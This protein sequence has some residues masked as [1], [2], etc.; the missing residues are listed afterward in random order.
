M[1]KKFK[2][3]NKSRK[4]LQQKLQQ[5]PPEQ[6][7]EQGKALLE[8]GKAR[9]A[10]EVLKQADKKLGP[11]DMIRQ[12]LFQAYL[13]REEQLR[14]KGMIPEA[15][16]VKNLAL[17]VMPPIDQLS[18]ADVLNMVSCASVQEA[19]KLYIDF[20]KSHP[21]SVRFDQHVAYRLM[22]TDDWQPLEMLESSHPIRRDSLPVREAVSRM[23]Q[24]EWEEALQVLKVVPRISPYAP[25]KLFCRAMVLFYQENDNEMIQT[26]SR[27]PDDFPLSACIESMK[28]SVGGNIDSEKSSRPYYDCSLWGGAANLDKLVTG[29]LTSLKNRQIKQLK[30]YISDLAKTIFP[31]S[32]VVAIQQILEILLYSPQ[33]NDI[34]PSDFIDMCESLLPKKRSVLVLLKSNQDNPRDYVGELMDYLDCLSSEISDLENRNMVWG[35]ILLYAARKLNAKKYSQKGI[36]RVNDANSKLLGIPEGCNDVNEAVLC[37]VVRSIELDPLNR[38]AYEFLIDLP[39]HSREAKDKVEDSLQKMSTE[40]PDDPFPCLELATLYYEKNAFRKAEHVLDEA[41]RR[42]PHDNRVIDRS[43]LSLVISA[44][45]N[46]NRKKHHLVL[47][48]LEKAEAFNSKRISPII[49]EKKILFDLI[50]HPDQFSK[51]TVDFCP[52]L[53]ILDRIRVMALLIL[54]MKSHGKPF[55]SILTESL[56]KWLTREINRLTLTTTDII[57]L[58]SPFPK[59]CQVVLPDKHIA[60]FLLGINKDLFGIIPDA[61]LI[62]IFELLFHQDILSFM[63]EELQKRLRKKNQTQVLSMQFFLITI[64]RMAQI[65][66][67]KES[68]QNVLAKADPALKKELET[69]SKKLSRHASGFLK[70]SLE[71][72]DFSPLE[73]SFLPFGFPGSR[74][75]ELDDDFDDD[76]DDD[77]DDDWED[78]DEIQDTADMLDEIMPFLNEF[79]SNMNKEDIRQVSGM[80]EEMVDKIDVRGMPDAEI[81]EVRN[82]FRSI[83]P[84]RKIFDAMGELIKNRSVV[85]ISREAHILLNGKIWKK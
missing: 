29:I 16:V 62:S 5:K 76:D 26:L 19:L 17:G 6:L 38:N 34:Y 10:I 31:E 9:D 21:P 35:M 30:S 68:Y 83:P 49:T 81:R 71:H 41:A 73:G 59:E 48:D 22:M 39:R 18:E 72:F 7:I 12:L 80:V 23:N 53:N 77:D 84:I 55:T 50:T 51:I 4:D 36:G 32:P 47:S 63:A 24:A 64:G 60:V 67:C 37:L 45:T 54:D 61:E 79:K 33:R 70:S 42:A 8:K 46:L 66:W 14:S 1:A 52:Q 58:L 43:A 40:F 57:T 82:L 25:I 2:K 65:S 44:C 11:S 28:Q 75:P 3:D 20:S 56:G 74:Y 27:I 85:G 78:F 13:Q 69:L 15:N